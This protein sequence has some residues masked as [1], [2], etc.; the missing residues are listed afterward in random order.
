LPFGII[1]NSVA[2]KATTNDDWLRAAQDHFAEIEGKMHILPDKAVFDSWDRLPIR[3]FSDA[4][5]PSE[6]YL[7]KEY[8]AM[9][10]R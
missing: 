7:V 10:H 5:G 6:D 8:V 3:A 2:R 9:H 1:Y 4:S